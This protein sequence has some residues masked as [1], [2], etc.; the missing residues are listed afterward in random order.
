[1]KRKAISQFILGG[2]LLILFVLFTWSLTFIDVQPIGPNGSSVA[3]AS[4]NH[5]VHKLFGVNMTLYNI[6]D[7]A[8]VVAIFIALGFAVLGLVQWVKRKR[9]L[10]VDSSILILGVFYILVFSAYVFFEFHVINRRPV[11]I[12]GILEAS[13]PSSTTMLAMCVADSYDAVPPFDK[14]Y[15]NQ[16]C[17]QR[18]GRFVHSVYGNWAADLRG[19]LVY[20]Y[21]WRIDF[22]HRHDF[23]LLLRKHL[24]F[25]KRKG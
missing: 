14:K 12:N 16:K 24:H 4:I 22:Q 19:T 21:T 3:Y 9:I 25:D 1:M 15:E 17:H 6:T 10:K 20:R 11:L 8:G 23:A 13:Y 5:A 2:I 18:L 7:W